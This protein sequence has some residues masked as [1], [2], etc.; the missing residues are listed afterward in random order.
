VFAQVR[1]P[2]AIVLWGIALA[3]SLNWFSS[4]FHAY[5]AELYPTRIRSRAIG[6]VYSWSRLSSIGVGFAVAATLARFGPTGVFAMIAIAMVLVAIVCA[7]FGP[8]T[9][10]TALEQI[11]P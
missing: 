2:I 11:S 3:L 7:A 4:A 10:R 1:S 8:Q 6:F 9:N 5:Q